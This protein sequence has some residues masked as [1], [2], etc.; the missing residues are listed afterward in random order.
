MLEEDTWARVPADLAVALAR[1]IWTSMLWHAEGFPG[2]CAGVLSTSPE[3]ISDTL[4]LMDRTWRAWQAAQEREERDVQRLVA[5]SYM[6]YTVVANI[7]Q[8]VATTGFLVVTPA[9]LQLLQDTFSHTTHQGGRG[10]VPALQGHGDSPPVFQEAEF[11]PKVVPGH[12]P[13]GA[14][15]GACLP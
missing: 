14:I 5:R 7:F 3:A 8:E 11:Q 10:W 6:N 15:R 2:A 4:S 13:K 12:P 9:I 1:Q